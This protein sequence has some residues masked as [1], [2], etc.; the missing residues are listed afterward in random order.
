MTRVIRN[1][2]LI[3]KNSAGKGHCSSR[4]WGVVIADELDVADKVCQCFSSSGIPRFT[5]VQIHQPNVTS[6][7]QSPLV[8]LPA[9]IIT[10]IVNHVNKDEKKQLSVSKL[11]FRL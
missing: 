8:R 5:E 10:I 1:A 7:E 9:E 11:P 3:A 2:H 4:I 6:Q